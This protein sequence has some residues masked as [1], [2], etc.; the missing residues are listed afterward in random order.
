M[1]VTIVSLV[2]SALLG[3]LLLGTMV[4]S[5][6]TVKTGVANSPA[7]A[8]A[9]GIEAQQALSTG[10]NAASTAAADIGGY[11]SLQIS[12]LSATQP[13][14]S[15]VS[16][17]SSS[18]STVS[19]SISTEGDGSITMADRSSDGIC[20]LLWRS[21]GSAVWYGAQT[22]LTSCAAPTLA[23]VPTVGPVSSTAIGWQQGSFP[24]A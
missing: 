9:D 14:T 15:F 7:V 13:S 5:G 17:P 24:A 11:G 8:A 2:V 6:S 23:S 12:A 22:G 16:G 18:A 10:L 1:V 20:W 4:H 19:V 3:A 21:T